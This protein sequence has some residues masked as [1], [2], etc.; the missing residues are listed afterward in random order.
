M[1]LAKRAGD[2]LFHM[3]FNDNHG[4]WDD[5]MIVGSVHSTIYIDLIYQLKK[6]GYTGWLSMDQYPYR[7]DATDAIAES[8][9]WVREFERIV[10]DNFAEIEALVE[11]NDAVATSRFVRKVLFS[12]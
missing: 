2:L 12:K 9:S 8:I 7:E 4:G 11:M 1:V 5:D 6:A 3:H 10:E